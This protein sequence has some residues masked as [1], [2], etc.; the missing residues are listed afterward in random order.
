MKNYINHN[1]QGYRG[2][3]ESE[4]GSVMCSYNAING[5]PNAINPLMR[6]VLR[7]KLGFGGFVIS[8]YDEMSN[9]YSLF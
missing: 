9:N 6:N 2:A 8:D 7:N 3:I 4:V 1:V 5:I